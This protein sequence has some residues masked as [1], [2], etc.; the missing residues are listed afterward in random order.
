[1][2]AELL[3]SQRK[4]LKTSANRVEV[5]GLKEELSSDIK[6][7]IY[8]PR[9]KD[10][11]HLYQQSASGKRMPLCRR[12]LDNMVPASQIVRLRYGICATCAREAQKIFSR[13]SDGGKT[14]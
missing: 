12:P 13:S 6:V 7:F 4:R 14:P 5:D 2:A 8:T 3:P 1:M 11:A 9:G 10:T